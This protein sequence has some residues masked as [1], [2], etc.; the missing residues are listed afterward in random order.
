[1]KSSLKRKNYNLDENKIKRAQRALHAKTETEAIHKALDLAAFQ[2]DALQ[3]LEKV[4]GK[5]HIHF[6]D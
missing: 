1:M 6:I 3:S 4:K 5:G 2:K